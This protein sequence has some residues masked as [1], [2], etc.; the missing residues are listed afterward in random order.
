MELYTLSY[1]LLIHQAHF[2]VKLSQDNMLFVYLK[3]SHSP[4]EIA[5]L[6]VPVQAN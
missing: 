6:A 1:S 3:M 4:E 2:Q 5:D